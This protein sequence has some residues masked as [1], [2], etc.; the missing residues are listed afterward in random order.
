MPTPSA[1]VTEAPDSLRRRDTSSSPS[2]SSALMSLK[3]GRRPSGDSS[4]FGCASCRAGDDAGGDNGSDGT[5]AACFAGA[6]DTLL[7]PASV[8]RR[9]DDATDSGRGTGGVSPGACVGAIGADAVGGRSGAA[10]AAS[11]DLASS[12]TLRLSSS[13][14]MYATAAV[15][16]FS[17]GIATTSARC[18][19]LA[20]ITKRITQHE[21]A[22]S[23]WPSG[24]TC[25]SGIGAA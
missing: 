14:V 11:G 4:G 2:S 13:P 15:A 12:S 25:P 18:C 22:S 19:V 8:L 6:G 17:E 10:S 20:P 5:T 3:L 9:G 1:A 21:L 16:I 7:M 24:C 23:G